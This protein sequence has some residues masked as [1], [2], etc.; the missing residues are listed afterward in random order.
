MDQPLLNLKT[1][2]EVVMEE[3]MRQ[4]TVKLTRTKTTTSA[5]AERE[6]AP[7]RSR[8]VGIAELMAAPP[9]VFDNKITVNA[10]D[11][12]TLELERPSLDQTWDIKLATSGDDI[13][14]TQLPPL[15]KNLHN[16]A[17]SPKTIVTHPYLR[18]LGTDQSGR[19]SYVVDSVN[20]KDTTLMSRKEKAALLNTIKKNVNIKFGLR[21]R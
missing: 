17:F 13:L 21:R 4:K 20:G 10:F 12:T 5:A 11:G 15:A 19:I 3:R 8:T 14:I 16:P 18:S 7:P 6:D 2:A 9:L 1:T